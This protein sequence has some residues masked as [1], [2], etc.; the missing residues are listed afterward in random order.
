MLFQEAL[1]VAVFASTLRGSMPMLLAALGETYAES[2]GIL[3]LGIEGMMVAGAF[4]SFLVGLQTNMVPLGFLGAVIIGAVLGGIT[5]FLV[6][7]LR[8]NQIVVGLGMTIF[9][10]AFCNLLHRIIFGSQFPM[11]WGA[12]M[13]TEIPVLSK[14]PIIGQPLFN[15]HWLV[16]VTFALIPALYF[17]L[18]RTSLGLR[19]R[20]VG[21]TPRAADASG[22]NVYGIRYFAIIFAG[23]L[24]STGGA[25]PAIGDLAFF[26]PDMVQ[27]RGYIA[28]VVVMLGKW[29]PIKVFLGSLLFGFALS[30]TS[31]LQVAGVK[32]S[33]D[34]ILTMP[35]IVVILTLIMIA[36][37]TSL[38][39][40]LCV[41]YKRGEQ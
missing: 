33:P 11:L 13:T 38:P 21:E 18:Y 25:F 29:N 27:G 26:V 10:S 31:A 12:G 9:T 2:A 32:I 40:A 37:S 36:K 22:V 14:I 35:Y 5:G 41:P 17:L 24:A 1:L 6:I 15:Q 34:F 7:R 20:A 23:V 16:Y 8:L 19:I 4:A 28:I 3:N 39:A 30:L